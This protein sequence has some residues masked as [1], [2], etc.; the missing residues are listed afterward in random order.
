MREADRARQSRELAGIA[1]AGRE[2]PRR[3]A[4]APV[5]DWAPARAA[6]RS[7]MSSS[8][9]LVRTREGRST[10]L[11]TTSLIIARETLVGERLV[12]LIATLRDQI[13]DLDR[14]LVCEPDRG[15]AAAWR[16]PVRTGVRG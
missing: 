13:R 4:P 5:P 8:A 6:V 9:A 7:A 12:D 3:S 15:S 11:L 1:S 10:A 2:A 14:S 16:F